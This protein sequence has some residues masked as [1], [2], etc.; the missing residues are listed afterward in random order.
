[1][2]YTSVSK[3][4]NLEG[5]VIEAGKLG[6]C[7]DLRDFSRGS[8]RTSKMAGLVEYCGYDEQKWIQK[9]SR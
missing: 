1:M 3:G 5:E 6:K 8:Q 2:R 4:R 9:D 7:K